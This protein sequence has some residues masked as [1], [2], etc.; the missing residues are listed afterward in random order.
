M[1]YNVLHNDWLFRQ[2]DGGAPLHAQRFNHRSREEGPIRLD[3]RVGRRAACSSLPAWC[4][5]YHLWW[6]V[7]LQRV[8]GVLQRR[9]CAIRRWFPCWRSKA[10]PRCRAVL[11]RLRWWV[12]CTWACGPSGTRAYAANWLPRC[13]SVHPC[14][15]LMASAWWGD[16]GWPHN[17]TKR[18]QHHLRVMCEELRNLSIIWCWQVRFRGPTG[19]LRFGKL[20]DCDIA[21]TR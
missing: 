8:V 18:G 16:A 10:L 13:V 17:A 20:V 14:H 11:V 4:V 9:P 19:P 7:P 6:A 1:L 5:L 3:V 2:M 15:S 12:R 21:T